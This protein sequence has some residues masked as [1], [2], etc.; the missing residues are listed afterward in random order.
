LPNADLK[1]PA[2]PPL[3]VDTV[4]YVG[5]GV[6]VVI[7]ESRAAATDAASLVDVE[8]EPLPGVTNPEIAVQSGAPQLH[9]DAPNNVVFRWPLKGGDQTVFQRAEVTIKQ[10]I[11]NQRLIPN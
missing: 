2:H 6:A 4:R 1:T 3:A 11:V 5:D 10:R 8:Y 9:G 7:A